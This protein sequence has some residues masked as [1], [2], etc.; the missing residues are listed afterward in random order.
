MRGRAMD[1]LGGID[2][3]ELYEGEKEKAE[4]AIKKAQE[5]ATRLMQQVTVP[6]VTKAGEPVVVGP[7]AAGPPAGKTVS[8]LVIIG[9]AIAGLLGIGFLTG[10]LR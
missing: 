7:V 3:N 10:K 2:L 4:E 9:L 6:D 5:E 8:P 1:A